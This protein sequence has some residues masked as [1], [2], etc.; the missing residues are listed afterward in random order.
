[1]NHKYCIIMAGGI[2]ARFWPISRKSAPKQFLDIL[3]TGKSL[4]RSTYERFV[5]IVPT[6][7]FIVVTNVAYKELVLKEIPELQEEQ[8]LCEPFRRN[9]TPC[10]AYAAFHLK[11]IDPEAEMIVTPSDHVITNEMHF[12]EVMLQA[13]DFINIVP[14]AM[15]TIGLKPTRPDTGYGYI[16]ISEKCGHKLFK[17]KTFTE[18]PGLEMAQ[19]FMNSG[20]FFWNSGI[21][22]WRADTILEAIKAHTPD[23]YELF[24]LNEASFHTPHEQTAIKNIYT[25]CRSISIDFGVMERSE[26]VYVRCTDIGWSDIG[27]WGSLYQFLPKDRES[28]TVYKDLYAFDTHG[29]MVRATGD[30]VVVID[31][32]KDYIVIDTEDALLICPQSHEQNIK[33]YI[34]SVKFDKGDKYN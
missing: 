13:I 20:E 15:V 2:G 24:A 4:I 5:N 22:V 17:V 1:M 7:N 32:L 34:E 3:G 9:T 33:K 6:E 27:T 10:I 26:H 11:A 8:I 25:E 21:F 28:N 16:Q 12:C 31:G 30:K 29:C 14:E 23:I 18:K 19:A